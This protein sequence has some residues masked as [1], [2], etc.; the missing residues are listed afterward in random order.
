MRFSKQAQNSKDLKSHDSQM[1]TCRK[2][3]VD[4][5]N[6]LSRSLSSNRKVALMEST[7]VSE[8]QN[9]AFVKPQNHFIEKKT[10]HVMSQYTTTNN[11]RAPSV[12]NNFD[13]LYKLKCSTPITTEMM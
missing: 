7:F 2:T 4:E 9:G 6:E 11:Y 13:D 1:G 12:S 10:G 3:L 8:K 5:L